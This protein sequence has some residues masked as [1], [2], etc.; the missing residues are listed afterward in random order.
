M[1]DVIPIIAGEGRKKYRSITDASFNNMS[2]ILE[3]ITAPKPDIYDGARPEQID[4]RVRHSLGSH[5]MPSKK[6]NIPAVGQQPSA[7]S[8]TW[9]SRIE[10][11]L[12]KKRTVRLVMAVLL[13]PPPP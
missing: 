8:V 1:A 2:P 4:P 9:Q 5:I 10:T 3:D 11:P 12:S 13:A 7:T 6:T